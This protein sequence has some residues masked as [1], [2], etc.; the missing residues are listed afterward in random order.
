MSGLTSYVDL[1]EAF[2]RLDPIR[3]SAVAREAEKMLWYNAELAKM[4][5]S[6]S[7]SGNNE[8][9]MGFLRKAY[10]DKWGFPPFSVA[11]LPLIR[12]YVE[13]RISK[14][15]VPGLDKY[16]EIIKPKPEG[17]PWSYTV[18]SSILKMGLSYLL[19]GSLKNYLIMIRG[20][21]GLGKTTY[22]F[23]SI[24]QTFM[25]IGFPMNTAYDFAHK[26]TF[27][28][29]DTWLVAMDELNHAKK[30][31]LCTLNDDFGVHAGKYWTFDAKTRKS[32]PK[33]SE[34]LQTLKDLVSV[35]V[36]TA[37]QLELLASFLRD[38]VNYHVFFEQVS[39]GAGQGNIVL[40]KWTRRKTTE[41]ARVKT[42]DVVEYLDLL[43]IYVR[44]PQEF[45]DEMTTIRAE[46]RAERIRS[47]MQE[48]YGNGEEGGEEQEVI[49]GDLFA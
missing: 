35:L 1:A 10:M 6:I 33:I 17:S 34:I 43:P 47:F 14:E 29:A 28:R 24:F 3:V 4:Y 39:L 22:T 2:Q 20:D 37:P 42:V 5:L 23:N 26:L 46:D 8:A 25:D 30:T 45:W 16:L 32:F 11:D 36:I 49:G 44:L 27:W 18:L 12:A 13:K 9:L 38:A 41:K 7:S 48:M 21:K 15:P 40:I 31:V 19:G